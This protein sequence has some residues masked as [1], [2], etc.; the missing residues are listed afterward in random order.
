MA[1]EGSGSVCRPWGAMI[2]RSRRRRAKRLPNREIDHGEELPAVLDP[3]YLAGG[4]PEKQALGF[5]LLQGHLDNA[6]C[7]SQR[8]GR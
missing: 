1:S 8:I 3:S 6:K 2:R 5:G 4:A 7:T